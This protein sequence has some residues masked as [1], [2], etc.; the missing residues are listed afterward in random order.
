VQQAQQTASD[1][2]QK[3]SAYAAAEA[4][5]SEAEK[6]INVLRAERRTGEGQLK[7]AQAQLGWP[8]EDDLHLHAENATGNYVKVVQ[9][10]SQRARLPAAYPPISPR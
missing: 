6:Q 4:A 3:Q 2:R 5:H 1:L 9:R 10:V 7:Q 8:V